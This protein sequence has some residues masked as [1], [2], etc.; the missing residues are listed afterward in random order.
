[1]PLRIVSALLL[2]ACAA[3]GHAQSID[4]AVAAGAQSIDPA[5]ADDVFYHFMPIAWRDSNNDTYR[6][7]DFGGMTASLDYLEDLGI[8]AV[9]MNPVFP[10][11]AYHG[12]QHGAADE[13]NA[14][15]GGET[16]FTGFIAAAH[17]RG[18]KVFVDMVCYGISHDSLW[19][20]SAYGNPASPYDDWLAFT[21]P[22]NT[23]YQGYT[24]TTWN[25]NTVG[26]I[27]W[28]LNNVHP[29]NLVTAWAQKWLDPNGDGDFTDG[30]DG[31]RLD[32]VWV[33]Y[34]YGP[35][36]W[37]YNLYDF[38]APWKAALQSVNPD[39]FIFAEQADW[40]ITGATLL[41]VFDATFAVPFMFAARS[42]LADENAGALY[43]STAAALAELPAGKAFL[44]LL[45]NHDVDRLTSVIG[46]SLTKA[47]MAAAVLMTQPFPP[48]VYYG[49]ELGMLGV[50]A[51]YGSDASDIPMREPFKWNA[52]A[53]PPMSN[54]WVLNA[55]AYN[56][57]YSQNNDGR[58]VEE[59]S[60]VAGSLLETYR[61]LIAA[62]RD[63]VALRRGSYHAVTASSSR[64]WSFLRYQPAEETL[65]VAINVY[66]SSRTAQLDLSDVEIAGGTT[67]PVDIITGQTFAAITE[68]NKAAY[69]LTVPGY[70]YRILAVGLVPGAPPPNTIDGANIP[71]DFYPGDLV[72][73]QDNATGMGD[74]INELNQMFV[75]PETSGLRIGITGNLASDG[76]GFCL[77]FD[78]VAGG[79]NTLNIAG[80]SQPPY[81]PG[82]LSGLKFDAGFAADYLVYANVYSGTLYVDQF[83]LP[84]SGAA[85]KVYRGSGTPNDGDGF[86]NGGTNP[87]GMQVALDNTNVLGVTESSAAG[88][89][90]A[91]T[92]FEMF[93]PHADI[94]LPA[95]P[96]ATIGVVAF[97]AQSGGAVGNQWL[98]G[99]GGGYPNLGVAPDL[100]TIP[101]QQ[102]A[103]LSLVRRG[104][105]NCDATV[106]LGDI[107]PFVLA[108][109]DPA[110]WQATYPTCPVLNGDINADGSI[111]LG[112]INPFVALLTGSL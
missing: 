9:W 92:G 64:I 97:I 90:T 39:V 54:Y 60:G 63:H 88:A 77:F 48:I 24:F 91:T 8:T 89:A 44:G 66:G 98:P 108:L 79:Q 53:G 40:G 3:V 74:N 49:D 37:G 80:Y 94:G 28:N 69:S 62:R 20:Q 85:T 96:D 86:L 18:I 84:S 38:W 111:D 75:H 104:D 2:L 58:S 102:Y 99:L 103:T 107:N 47:K 15:F 81:I 61:T 23:Q 56:N 73:T 65:L 83:T 78:T 4:P 36:G 71:D 25:G 109:T 21:N 43:S 101:G 55:P 112:D 87:N 110:T 33:Q 1:M 27:N 13:L 7:G 26:F 32:H 70:G 76:T 72:A 45:G 29:V 42:A 12:Y 67:T 105:L 19:F 95:Q 51:N 17:A 30:L 46:G 50:K 35:N 16:D 11:P 68:A 10:S 34:A 100:T 22:S 106:D 14:W 31:Y 93:I 52:V 82:E 6:F 5:V 41:P 59:Q 57:R